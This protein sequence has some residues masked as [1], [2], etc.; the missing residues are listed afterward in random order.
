MLRK[1]VVQMSGEV[2]HKDVCRTSDAVSLEYRFAVRGQELW[3]CSN[4][5]FVQRFR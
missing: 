5:G 4:C 3:R 1:W 2:V